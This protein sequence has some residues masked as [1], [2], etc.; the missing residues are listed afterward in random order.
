M[1][2]YL[3]LILILFLSSCFNRS[4]SEDLFN[5]PETISNLPPEI[6]LNGA[7][8][9]DIEKG[10]TFIDPGATALDSTDGNLSSFVIIS[11]TLD[12][13]AVGTYTLVYSITDSDGN[14]SSI[15]RIIVVSLDIPPIITLTGS[16]TI[17]IILGDNF[18]DP[19]ATAKDNTDGDLTSSITA[20]GTVDV[21]SAGT[22][23]IVYSVFDSVGNLT[24]ET[25]TIIVREALIYFEDGTCKCP[26]AKI[27]DTQIIN[28]TIYIAVD[29]STVEGQIVNEYFN[30]C[31][32][33][34]TNMSDF[35]VNNSSFNSDISFWDTS[36]VVSMYQMFSG[37]TLFNQDISVWDVGKVTN[38]SFM[39]FE[40]TS[41]NQDI[42]NWD[43][44]KVTIFD[45]MF[46][47]ATLFNQD[48]GNWNISSAI[49]IQSMFYNASSFNQDIGGWNTS[50]VVNMGYV[51][52]NATLFN[53]DIGGWDTANVTNMYSLF[54]GAELFNKHIG[55]WNTSNVTNMRNIFKNA[56]SFNQDI[57]D[58]DTSKLNIMLGM[59]FNASSFNQDL[60]SWCVKNFISEPINF[61]TN[62]PLFLSNNTPVW[63]TC[64]E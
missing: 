25:R 12:T 18:I 28:G 42:G 16:S 57:G 39:F 38:M 50:N 46:E 47:D 5:L 15:T 53:Q 64:P 24:T 41:F 20:S 62:S 13:S 31:T 23:T 32:T 34:V 11:G 36:S 1:N 22:Y 58:W 9:I 60:T 29:N 30:L 55:D 54:Q 6:S 3:T 37:A 52:K 63:G 43:T 7:F 61:S 49:D 8:K 4:L 27:G 51:F 17:N 59:F 19:G 45:R 35:F 10:G 40:A 21:F 26:N 48:I 2:R 56:T 14:S 44:A 33:L